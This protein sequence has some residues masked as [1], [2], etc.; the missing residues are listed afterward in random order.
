MGIDEDILPSTPL[1]NF[2]PVHYNQIIPEGTICLDETEWEKLTK[3][4]SSKMQVLYTDFAI[5]LQ[6]WKKA[7]M[8]SCEDLRSGQENYVYAKFERVY[9]LTH[10][11]Q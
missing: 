3:E 6:E 11:R 9:N 4:I 1:G 8:R 2:R 5:R 10:F 7:Y